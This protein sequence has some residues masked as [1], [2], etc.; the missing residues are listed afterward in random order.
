[1]TEPIKAGD[2]CIVIDGLGQSKSPNVGKVVTVGHRIYGAH[3]MDHTRFGPVVRCKG[4]GVVQLGE[5]GEYV[6]TGWADFP[7][8]WLRRIEPPPPPASTTTTHKEVAA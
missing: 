3:G 5:T 4:E 7:T 8:A 2:V 1:M 6:T